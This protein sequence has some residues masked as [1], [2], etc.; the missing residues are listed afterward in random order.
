MVSWRVS[1]LEQHAERSGSYWSLENKVNLGIKWEKERSWKEGEKERA[2]FP[3]ISQW[4][5]SAGRATT[6]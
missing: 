3:M 4:V 1:D 6:A 2:L 5:G